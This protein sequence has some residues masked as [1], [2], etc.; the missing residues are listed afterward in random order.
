MS[1]TIIA[2][3][4]F[5]VEYLLRYEGLTNFLVI[6]AIDILVVTTNGSYM[7]AT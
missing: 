6:D 1:V 4:I 2:E 3:Y 5:I 7:P